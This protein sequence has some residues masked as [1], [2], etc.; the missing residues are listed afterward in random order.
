MNLRVTTIAAA[1]LL[2]ASVISAP[3]QA[4]G[5]GMHGGFGHVGGGWGHGGWGHGGWGWEALALA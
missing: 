1:G 5:F 2:V 4:R 3:A